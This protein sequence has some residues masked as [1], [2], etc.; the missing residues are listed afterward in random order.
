LMLF[1]GLS[2]SAVAGVFAAGREAAPLRNG[3]SLA[4]ASE[5]TRG[6]D[7]TASDS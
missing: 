7:Y 3:R 2:V 4:Q 1:D 5:V 6:L